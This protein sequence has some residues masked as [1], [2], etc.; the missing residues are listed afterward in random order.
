MPYLREIWHFKPKKLLHQ[1]IVNN[2]ITNFFA[3]LLQYNSKHRIALFIVLQ[4]K[5]IYI[6]IYI[7]LLFPLKFLSHP[8]H[9]FCSLLSLFLL[10][11]SI[12]SLLFEVSSSKFLTHLTQL[13]SHLSSHGFSLIAP[14]LGFRF[15]RLE[16][17][18]AWISELG[19]DRWAR[20]G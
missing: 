14:V 13:L 11:F 8:S 15:L 9:F 10:C 2:S 1:G 19:L 17:G 4:K 5:Y 18:S 20:I 12:C 7:L 6:Y 16:V 3:I